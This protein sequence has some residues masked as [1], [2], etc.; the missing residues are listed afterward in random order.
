MS[1]QAHELWPLVAARIR[2]DHGWSLQPV[3]W[4]GR[5]HDDRCTWLAEGAPGTVIVKASTNAFGFERAEW[6]AEALALLHARGVP[7]PVP[8]WWGRVDER[9]WALV[10]PQLPGELVDALDES[11]LVCYAAIAR[12]A[13]SRRRGEHDQAEVWRRVTEA[14]LDAWT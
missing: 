10:Q 9:W 4:L 13:L 8:L 11:V 12:L 2:S 5:S 1:G 7:V 6:A 14:V 3:A